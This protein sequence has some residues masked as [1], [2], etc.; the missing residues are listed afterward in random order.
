MS[1]NPEAF[2]DMVVLTVKAALGPILERL[3]SAEARLATLASVE[4]VSDVRNRIAIVETKAAAPVSIQDAPAVDLAPLLE[5]LAVLDAKVAATGDLRDRVVA[6]ETKAAQPVVAEVSAGPTPAEIE[7]ALRDKIEPVTKHVNALSERL[8]VMEVRAPLPG[9]PG[10][11]GKD[12]LNGKDGVDGLGFDDM[13]VEFDGDRTVLLKFARGTKTKAW[14][15]VFPYLK[16]Q[17]VYIEGKSY[18]P[19][20]LATWGGSMW[21]CNEETSTKPGDGSKAWTLVVK[22]GRDG[23]DGRDAA[24]PAPMVKVS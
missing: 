23:K 24:G 11:D 12:G 4:S 19:G 21:H 7:L 18:M 14:P 3:A 9:P 10:Q 20:D 15:L 17:G 1:R 13:D 16:N 6:M 22:R 5:R 2:A 8:A